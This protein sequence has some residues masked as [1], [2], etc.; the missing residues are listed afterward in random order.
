MWMRNVDDDD[1]DDGDD[2][3]DSGGVGAVLVEA[4]Y[5]LVSA[6]Y[7]VI[8]CLLRLLLLFAAVTVLYYY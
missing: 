6:L 3:C 4:H 1:G 5:P 2:E 8:S 7:G